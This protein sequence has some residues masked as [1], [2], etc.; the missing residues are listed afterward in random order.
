MEMLTITGNEATN[1]QEPSGFLEKLTAQTNPSATS[2]YGDYAGAHAVA[3]DGIH[4]GM[5]TE[6]SSVIGVASLPPCRH[7]HSDG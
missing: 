3:V 2:T 7:H 6:V 1:P 5:E 4:A